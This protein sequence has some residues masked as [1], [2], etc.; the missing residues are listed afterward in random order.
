M[1]VK[2]R[3]VEG[4]PIIDIYLEGSENPIDVLVDTGFNGELM[5]TE[6]KI[7]DLSLPVIG[8]NEY[9][10]ASGDVVPTTVYIGIIRWFGRKR[11]ISVLATSGKTN[12]IGMEL[13]HFHR[14]EMFRSRDRLIISKNEK[15]S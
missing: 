5:L 14:L 8:D 10:T 6:D 13:M 11:K 9:M 4:K 3:F 1:E 15:P 2:G 7:K 12:L